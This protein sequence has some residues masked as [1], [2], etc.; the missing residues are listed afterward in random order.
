LGRKRLGKI[1]RLKRRLGCFGILLIALSITG[2]AIASGFWLVGHVHQESV[3]SEVCEITVYENPLPSTIVPG[4]VVNPSF[5][6]K[7]LDGPAELIIKLEATIAGIE[8]D[9]WELNY[10]F[11]GGSWAIWDIENC[12]DIG[13]EGHHNGFQVRLNGTIKHLEDIPDN[14]ASIDIT[15]YRET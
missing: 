12:I 3:V 8:V 6:I 5:S 11:G 10:S 13:T 1:A 7:P 14:L 9:N 15:L 2:G 4:A